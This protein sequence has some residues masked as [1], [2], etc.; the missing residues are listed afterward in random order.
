[1]ANSLEE[2]A[3]ALAELSGKVS[4]DYERRKRFQGA[5]GPG[6]RGTF[7]D[8]E[9]TEGPDDG[10]SG[11]GHGHG[12]QNWNP[13][14][15]W[16]SIIYG[17]EGGGAEELLASTAGKILV[18]TLVDGHVIPQ[19]ADP[20]LGLTGLRYRTPVTSIL[21]GGDL[22]WSVGGELVETLRALE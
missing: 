21:G 4:S 17:G 14:S 7:N 9:D 19:W 6:R 15:D 11:G 22:V 1:M 16:G 13:M 18:L 20:T 10:T 3:R 12:S 8:D 2:L 5:Y